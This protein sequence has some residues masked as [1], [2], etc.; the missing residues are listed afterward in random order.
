MP[1][2]SSSLDTLPSLCRYCSPARLFAR[3]PSRNS[4]RARRRCTTLLPAALLLNSS[5]SYA[6]SHSLTVATSGSSP[7]LAHTERHTRSCRQGRDLPA[8]RLRTSTKST[9]SEEHTSEL[10]SPVHLVCRL[11]LEKKKD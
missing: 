4:V 2:C 1:R 5:T 7:R 9:R 11:L 8:I 6:A 10:Q 3:Y